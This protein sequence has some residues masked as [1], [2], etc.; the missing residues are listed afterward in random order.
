M[1]AII[2]VGVAL[3]IASPAVAQNA[4]Y[5]DA[6]Y[7]DA[8]YPTAPATFSGLRVEARGGYDHVVVELNTDDG[9]TRTSDKDHFDG[10]TYGGEVGYD[11]QVNGG[12]VLGL[13]G[14]FEQSSAKACGEGDFGQ[15]ICLRAGRNFIAGARGGYLL[16]A[17]SLLYIKGGYS[18]AK[19]NITYTDPDFPEDDFRVSDKFDGFHVGAGAQV[20]FGH[21]LYGK[22]EYVYTDYNG[23]EDT[24]LG[25]KS[26]SDFSRHQVTAGLGIK[27]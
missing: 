18:N 9:V 20:G 23:Y 15:E 4:S 6:P 19:M 1:K 24:E 21:R 25:V 17:S 27:F 26:S 12:T 16:G 7:P 2:I 3:G 11:L 13:Y 14:G 8:P 5:P 10:V 22:L